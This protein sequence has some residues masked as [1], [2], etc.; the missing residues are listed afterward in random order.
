M[1][2]TLKTIKTKVKLNLN[3]DRYTYTYSIKV[4]KYNNNND[5]QNILMMKL[6]E[7][8]GHDEHNFKLYEKMVYC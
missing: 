3:T 4:Y 1:H 5:I 7:I 6:T 2:E 8:E